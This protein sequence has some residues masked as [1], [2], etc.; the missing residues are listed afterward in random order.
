MAK[1]TGDTKNRDLFQELSSGGKELRDHRE[2]RVTLRSRK[3]EPVMVFQ[4]RITLMETDPPIW[5]RLRVAGDTT[6]SSLDTII[7]TAM[8]WT[9][10]H[11]H[12]FA[13][14]GAVYG[15]P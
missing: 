14:G 2:G 9:N 3:V 12:T 7:Q 10:S 13:A 1:R 15:S 11:L 4:L 8:G 6:L 5:R